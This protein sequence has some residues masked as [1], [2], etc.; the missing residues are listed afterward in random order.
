LTEAQLTIATPFSD[1]PWCL[2]EWLACLDALTLPGRENRVGL[3]WLDNSR[4]EVFSARLAEEAKKREG[5]WASVWVVR[6]DTQ[7]VQDPEQQKDLQ[8]ALVR[9]ES[10]SV[11]FDAAVL[12]GSI[13]WTDSD[14]GDNLTRDARQQIPLSPA[15]V[16]Q[17]RTFIANLV[18]QV[19]AAD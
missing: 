16:T 13:V 10:D 17:V 2:D 9:R 5:Q 15:Q 6:D 3:L 7:L 18:A 4:D 8:V 14:S 1:R 11:D 12:V 19:K